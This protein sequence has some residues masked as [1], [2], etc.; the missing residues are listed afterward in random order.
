MNIRSLVAGL[1]A[2]AAAGMLGATVLATPAAAAPQVSQGVSGVPLAP[3]A[4]M[5]TAGELTGV[6]TGLADP[7]VPFIDKAGLLQGGI[8]P[9]YAAIADHKLQKAQR[10]GQLPLA[11]DVTNIAPAGPG[12]AT[13]DVT[14]SG[15]QLAPRTM[16]IGFVDQ[17][18]W[19]LSTASATELLRAASG[20]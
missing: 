18:G 7:A 12:E 4:G 17:D 20:K 11:F 6:L 14:V 9:G 13:A 8:D 15:P 2:F 10:K 1:A 19:R 3:A 5:P 16:N